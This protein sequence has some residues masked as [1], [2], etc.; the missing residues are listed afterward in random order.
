MIAGWLADQVDEAIEALRGSDTGQHAT[1]EEALTAERDL[2]PNV[3]RRVAADPEALL[4]ALIDVFATSGV[5]EP[6]E[7][8]DRAREQ[9]AFEV[10]T[11]LATR[12]AFEATDELTVD[13]AAFA[14]TW[15]EEII[16]R[17][18]LMKKLAKVDYSHQEEVSRR[19]SWCKSALKRLDAV[20]DHSGIDDLDD[21]PRYVTE[22][23]LI[24]ADIETNIRLD[25]DDRIRKYRTELNAE[26]ADA[27]LAAR[28]ELTLEVV[29]DRIALLR[30]GRSA[31]TFKAQLEGLVTEFTPGFVR[32]AEGADWPSTMVAYERALDNAGPL[33]TDESRHGAALVFLGLY[34]EICAA[35]FKGKPPTPKLRAFF[36]EVGFE[37]VK[38]SGI[39]RLG[40]TKSWHMTMFGDLRSD[41]WFLPPIFGSKAT[42]GYALFLIGPDTLPE[43]IQKALD[44]EMP[45]ILLLSGVAD[46]AR[47][48]EFAERLRATVIPAL[49][50][51]EALVAFAAT[52]RDTRARTVFECGLPYGRV[53]PYTTDA[54]QV[55]TEMFFGREAEIRDIMS[56]TADGCLVYGGRQ[57]G[58]SALLNHVART[59]HAP[60]DNR[61]VVRREVKA[62]GNSEETSEIWTHLNAML[63]RDGVVKQSSRTADAVTRDIRAWLATRP[64]GQVVCLFDETDHFMAAD[65][66][67]DYPQLS[68]LKELME[69]T[70]RAFK[71][72][73][74]G[75]HNVKRMH[76]QPNSP[77]AH[78][79]RAICIGP[80]NRT[81]DDK[82]AAHD[83]VIAP[84]RAAGF[85]FES[86]EAVEEIL[87]WANYYPSLVQE[88]ARGLLGT[89]HGA[90]SGMTYRLP[91][92][93]P[94]WTVPTADLFAHRGFPQIELRIREKFHLTIELDPRYALVAYTLGRLNAEGYENQALVSG[95]RA[96]ELLEHALNFWPKN[97]ERPSQAAFDA[98]L[99]ELFDLGVLGRVPIPETQLFTYCLRTRQV[100]AMLGSREDIEHALLELEEKDPTVDYD[101]TI[102]RRRYAP[103]D[104]TISV[105][106]KDLPYSPLTDFQ[107][108]RLL[109]A[110]GAPARIVCGLDELGLSKVGI[111]LKR[112]AA[113]G[114]LPGVGE[115]DVDVVMTDGRK[116]IRPMLDRVRKSEA[117][118]MLLIHAPA[119]AAEATQE[120]AWLEEQVAVLNGN[121]RPVLLLNA[122]DAEMRALANRRQNQSEF[123]AA[124]GVEMVRVHLSNIECSEL[125]TPQMRK[126]ILA[127]TGGIPNDTVKLINAIV[128]A[129]DQDDVF[130]NWEPALWQSDALVWGTLGQALI[131]VEDTDDAGDYDALDDMIRE[132]TGADLITHGPD[133]VATGLVTILNPKSK[134][135][136]RSALGDL[137]AKQIES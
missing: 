58:K 71:V 128:Q 35:I 69:D 129:Q 123:L 134:R 98:L 7:A 5:P 119:S 106:Q 127:A 41:G 97:A 77:L 31:A 111:A 126:K 33:A 94:L 76:R 102:H 44:P 16:E 34:R 115:V 61:I 11:R 28:D 12:Y 93:G 74:A 23:D 120:L 13:M 10:A 90:G 37:N 53:E 99:D 40:R 132:A 1:V 109:D 30:D 101:R 95:F 50:I 26:D 48:R 57:L 96:S 118:R 70:E 82:R 135:V 88:Y 73:F 137:L 52:R 4:G 38:V 114:L 79:G 66:K 19:L 36:E 9:G 2:L 60:E 27:L 29:E 91:K 113:A 81:E 14:A 124:W 55:P 63:V 89:L 6:R 83:L 104:K 78:L 42:S 133:L 100:A 136:R 87:A 121:V 67:D 18:R 131:M 65:T 116:D 72:V 110:D 112:I 3:A 125:D 85:K 46:L 107:I 21:I 25:Q 84:M 32:V 80:L 86:M 24:S 68:R 117:R 47:R 45:T 54:G 56:K 130:M 108:E 49:L 20:A 51:D 43:A 92:D 75:L 62:L 17:E 122:A 15:R 39:S 59:R 22:F 105:A 64:N 8:Y 103:P